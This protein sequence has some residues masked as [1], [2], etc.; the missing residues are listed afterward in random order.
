MDN[1]KYISEVLQ[2]ADNLM[3]LANDEAGLADESGFGILLAVCRDCAYKIRRY[4]EQEGR[5]AKR[6]WL[7]TN[8][9]LVIFTAA[10]LSIIFTPPVSATTVILST[11]ATETLGGLSFTDGALAEYNPTTDT[12]TLFFDENLFSGNENIVAVHVLDNG[13][14]ILSTDDSATL[15]GLSFN[16]GDLVEY[17]PTTDTAILFFDETLFAGGSENIDAVHILDNGNII[18]SSSDDATLGGLTFGGGDLV[19]YNPITDTATLFFDGSLFGG[20]ENLDAAHI[21]DNGNIILSTEGG[22]TLG[23][24]TFAD[25]DLVEYNPTTNVATLYFSEGLFSNNADVDA[26]YVTTVPEPATM[27]L[28]GLGM[29]IC[30]IRR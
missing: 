18:L 27:A 17:N 16:A 30:V 19:E 1:H 3:E 29:L 15:G 24:L 7:N 4:A 28:L 5:K 23:G 10:L 11:D 2:I 25:G 20:S 14:I 22:A 6:K 8:T 13:N 26:V 21:L 12:A 9:I